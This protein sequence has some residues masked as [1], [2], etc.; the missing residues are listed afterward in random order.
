MMT[1]K[2]MPWC[3]TCDFWAPHDKQKISGWCPIHQIVADSD[4]W[5]E[6][7]QPVIT[8]K[9]MT[10]IPIKE[11]VQAAIYFAKYRNSNLSEYCWSCDKMER[12]VTEQDELRGHA[13]LAAAARILAAEVERLTKELQ[14]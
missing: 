8:S 12:E 6:R 2:K 10:S 5:C 11:A 9:V 3:V 14:S 4:H 13:Q 1:I 7:H